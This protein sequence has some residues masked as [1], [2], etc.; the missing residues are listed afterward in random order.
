MIERYPDAQI[1]ALAVLLKHLVTLLPGLQEIAGHED[2]DTEL[3][4]SEDNS[5]IMIRRKVDP[6]PCFPWQTILDNTVLIRRV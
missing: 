5:E 6:G 1:R 2:L 3:L 4:P